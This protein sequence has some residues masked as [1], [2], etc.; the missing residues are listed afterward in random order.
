MN[1]STHD[2]NP[3][4]LVIL[5]DI[6]PSSLSKLIKVPPASTRATVLSFGPDEGVV[7][8]VSQLLVDRELDVNVVSA[9]GT[10]DGVAP[11]VIKEYVQL[12]ADAP[13]RCRVSGR[14]LK[15]I[16]AF[17]GRLSL[18]WLNEISSKRSDVYP[19]FTRLCQ[20]EVIRRTVS[21]TTPDCL[22]LLTGDP[23]FWDVVSSY[24][25]TSGIPF[26]STRPE[27]FTKSRVRSVIRWVKIF[28]GLAPWLLETAVQTALAKL[29]IRDRI[30]Q[31]TADGQL[32][33]FYTHYPNLWRG[34]EGQR[35]EKY[36]RVPELVQSLGNVPAFYACSFATDTLHQR[37]ST[38]AY[39]RLCRWLRARREKADNVSV[40][41]VDR[42]LRWRDLVRVSLLSL[43]VVLR[44]LWLE[45][46]PAFRRQWILDGVDIFPLIRRELRIAAYRIPR[47]LLHLIRVRRFIYR[48]NPSCLSM[49]LFEF[50]YGRAMVYAAKTAGTPPLVIGVQHGP[51][52]HRR[53]MYDFASG[54]LLRDPTSEDN[55]VDNVPIPDHIFLEGQS[56]LDTL[57][58]SGYPRSRLHVLGAPRVDRLAT[59]RRRPT[60]DTESHAVARSVLVTFGQHDGRAILQ[61]CRPVL[62]SH[63][64]Y[65]F[66]FKIHPRS[67]MTARLT[68]EFLKGCDAAS[69][70]E[71]ASEDFYTLLEQ[72]DAVIA[73]YSST[74]LEAAAL[75]YPVVC[76]HLPNFAS[77]SALLDV[78]SGV[79]WA[80]SP[81]QLTAALDDSLA[82]PPTT[83]DTER[84]RRFFFGKLDGS[85][86]RRWAEAIVSL[87]RDSASLPTT[88]HG[89]EAR[90]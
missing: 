21:S 17:E 76:I 33:A 51:I 54:E 5:D 31:P 62:E 15:E 77:P 50:C 46:R 7:E 37:V 72:S 49:H 85:A 2:Q 16:F 82:H 11:D 75:G 41:L 29:L 35:D 61:L 27:G 34:A 1:I 47:Y 64:G 43:I 81:Q 45:R 84:L 57:L 30:P 38:W 3:V 70:Y 87:M 63:T 44:H 6:E 9:A 36:Q 71:V 8:A 23:D 86:D 19:L 14:S 55:F 10:L 18:W 66:I 40:H 67:A 89:A 58:E 4:V 59:L 73:T 22:V 53:T 42:D 32:C 68:E 28:L 90:N 65:H 48:A 60:Q 80:A 20:L 39:Y 52:T 74:G 24:C 83:E 78:E 56:A 13:E 88:K 25:Q 79:R 26:E 69:S 12:V